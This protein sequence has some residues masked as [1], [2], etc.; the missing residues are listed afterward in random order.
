M[1]IAYRPIFAY[2]LVLVAAACVVGSGAA[3]AQS[4]T[5]IITT[6]SLGQTSTF[7]I[8]NGANRP[9]WL[10]P[11]LEIAAGTDDQGRPIRIGYL[12]Y[13]I[14]NNNHVYVPCSVSSERIE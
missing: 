2:A 7:D 4:G 8:Q 10:D 12:N 3:S 11:N 6:R 5:P 9:G 13:I 14:D 1:R